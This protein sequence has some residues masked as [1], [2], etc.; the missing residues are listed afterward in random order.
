MEELNDN[1]CPFK[2]KEKCHLFCPVYSNGNIKVVIKMDIIAFYN[3]S[4][5]IWI[6]NQDESKADILYNAPHCQ[7]K[8]FNLLS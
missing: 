8:F 3:G 5:G 2:S 7:D 6:L 4:N 1:I